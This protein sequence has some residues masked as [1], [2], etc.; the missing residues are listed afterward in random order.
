MGFCPLAGNMPGQLIFCIASYAY[1]NLKLSLQVAYQNPLCIVSGSFGNKALGLISLR[2]TIQDYVTRI[3]NEH[4]Y[5]GKKIYIVFWVNLAPF[6]HNTFTRLAHNGKKNLYC[7]LNINCRSCTFHTLI[8]GHFYKAFDWNLVKPLLLPWS[9]GTY[10]Y[11][12]LSPSGN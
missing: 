10:I 4:A 6:T 1:Q 8:S 11:T 9:E 5:N 7:V 2:T 3:G 12:D